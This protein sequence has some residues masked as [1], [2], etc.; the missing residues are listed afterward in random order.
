MPLLDATQATAISQAAQRL[1]DGELLAFPTETVYGL[2]ARADDDAAVARIFQAKGRPHDH[3]LIVHTADGEQAQAFAARWPES[4]QALSR[5]FW[6]GPLTLIVPRTTGLADAAAGGHATIGLRVPGHPLAAALLRQAHA[7]G[8]RGVAAPSA[9]RFGRISATA[10]AHVVQEFGDTLW[11]LDGGECPGGIESTIVDCSRAMPALLRPG[12]IGR[13]QIE[14][15]L[16]HVLST[17]AGADDSGAPAAPGTLQA[18][19]AP[20]AKLRLM[21]STQL[22]DALQLLG[23]DAAAFK[24]AVYS[25]SSTRPGKAIDHHRMPDTAAAAAHEI[26]AVLRGFDQRGARLIWV[27]SPPDGP[28]WDGVRDRLQRAAAA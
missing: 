14:A 9:N 1:A 16:G 18:H 20:T 5:A 28:E 11:V 15:A 22:R 21:T 23:A 7:L 19:Y 26:Y 6:P 4:A 10:A 27:E 17:T 12:L 24:L 3:P 13:A 2:G 8:V 25:R